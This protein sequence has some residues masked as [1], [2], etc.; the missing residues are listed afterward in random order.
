MKT[1]G[2]SIEHALLQST[3]G[4]ALCTGSRSNPKQIED[5]SIDYPSKNNINKDGYIIFHSHTTPE[6]F[7]NRIKNKEIYKNYKWCSMAR[8]PWE[9]C[10]SYFWF[11]MSAH[12]SL[13]EAIKQEEFRHVF[14]DWLNHDG[15]ADSYTSAEKIQVTPI[16]LISE[17]NEGCIS[18]KID[19]YIRFDKLQL[20]YKTVTYLLDVPSFPLRK[21]KSSFKQLNKHY[22]WYYSNESRKLVEE[23]FPKTIN[24]FKYKFEKR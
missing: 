6:L 9:A 5:K 3:G 14:N 22:S 20:D 11:S 8:N 7:W 13:S 19:Y 17:I 2:S 1:G 12:A 16:Q 24:K 4:N 15:E 23:Y 18:E 21:F 10:V